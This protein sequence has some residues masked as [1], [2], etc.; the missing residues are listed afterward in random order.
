MD[1]LKNKI[2]YCINNFIENSNLIIN[3]FNPKHTTIFLFTK[4]NLD[5]DFL[6]IIA[7]T[8]IYIDNFN[9]AIE[10]IYHQ[11]ESNPQYNKI[12]LI[13]NLNVEIDRL[14]ELNI[15]VLRYTNQFQLKYLYQSNNFIIPRPINIILTKKLTLIF[16]NS[17]NWQKYLDLWKE[18]RIIYSKQ[19]NWEM[20]DYLGSIEN[21]PNQFP[22]IDDTCNNNKNIILEHIKII[23]KLEDPNNIKDIKTINRDMFEYNFFDNLQENNEKIKNL[24]NLLQL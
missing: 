1:F 13:N 16:H 7:P 20:I 10:K 14:E 18:K 4:T 2:N 19:N 23:T 11:A 5:N 15:T 22:I 8:Q 17:I 6:S 3:L 12:I 24:F 9:Q 21:N